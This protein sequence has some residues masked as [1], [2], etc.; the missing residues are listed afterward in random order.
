[1]CGELLATAPTAIFIYIVQQA[2]QIRKI[3]SC[4]PQI[5]NINKNARLH[6][7]INKAVYFPLLKKMNSAIMTFN[8]L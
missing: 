5:V 3:P 4:S 8:S 6:F 2:E 7:V 1:M